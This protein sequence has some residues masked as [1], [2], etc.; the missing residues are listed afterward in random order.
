[1]RGWAG[2][3]AIFG[4]LVALAL[5]F[6]V[7]LGLVGFFFWLFAQPWAWL[8]LA[9]LLPLSVAETVRRWQ[10]QPPPARLPPVWLPFEQF[11]D[12][13]GTALVAGRCRYCDGV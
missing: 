1:M 4:D 8:L 7:V 2:P 6:L 5:A 13:C 12:Q 11:C 10:H 9:G 3:L